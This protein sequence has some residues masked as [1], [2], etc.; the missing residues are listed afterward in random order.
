MQLTEPSTADVPSAL[1]AAELE[2]LGR[3]TAGVAHDFNNILAVIMVCASEIAADASD[4]AQRERAEE[5]REAAERGAELS[6]ELLAKERAADSSPELIDVDAAVADSLPLLR[7]ILGPRVEIALG[8]GGGLPRVR[9]ARGELERVLVNL[10]AN[11]R[12]AIAGAGGVA[13][14]TSEVAVP[15]GDP[16]LGAGTHVRIGF[17]DDGCGM[18]P[19]VAR[20]AVEPR[21]TTKG[22]EG[23]GLGLATAQALLRDR[24][25]DL[26]INTMAGAG[27][28]IS[29]YLPAVDSAGDPLSL[30]PPG[31]SV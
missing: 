14:H 2:Q 25:G 28:T 16:H 15:A 8:A 30:S 27:T 31:A 24:G 23:S 22:R 1:G 19:E 18:P 11:S 26:R 3:M 4:A 10:A 12:D 6:R 5:I 9:I 20:R 21:F 29:L 7:R 13:I 17:S